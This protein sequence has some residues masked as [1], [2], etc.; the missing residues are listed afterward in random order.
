MNSTS[1]RIVI[2]VL[3]FVVLNFLL[4]VK[5]YTNILALFKSYTLEAPPPLA[6]RFTDSFLRQQRRSPKSQS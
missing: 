2:A 4:Q 1:D 6:A 3:V 5:M